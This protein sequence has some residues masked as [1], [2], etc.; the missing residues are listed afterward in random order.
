MK[1]VFFK[2]DDEI[3]L[4]L[5]HE[6]NDEEFNYV[7]LI[8]FLHDG[9]ELEDTEYYEDISEDEKDKINDMIQKINEKVVKLIV[10]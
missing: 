4:K 10:V 3:K 5:N 9:K 8:E 6:G 2:E 1:L 7:R